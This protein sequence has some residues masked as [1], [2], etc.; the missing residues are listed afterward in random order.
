MP[1]VRLQMEVDDRARVAQRWGRP[2]RRGRIEPTL[3]QVGERAGANP[4]L[5]DLDEEILE[6]A[7]SEAL[8]PVYGLGDPPLVT[9]SVDPL[10]DAELPGIPAALDAS[11][12]V[13]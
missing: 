5:S 11:I 10:V 2:A 13:P 4:S 12:R 3:Q 7:T 9:A 6:L 1:E 8:R